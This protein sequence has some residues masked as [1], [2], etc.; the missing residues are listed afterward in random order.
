VVARDR[1]V[2]LAGG[3]PVT[4]HRVPGIAD[5]AV[6]PGT[7]EAA[8]LRRADPESVVTLGDRVIFRG[9]GDFGGL[10]WSPDGRML[11]V[12]WPTADQWVFVRADGRSRIAAVSNVREQFGGGRFPSVA[13]WCCAEQAG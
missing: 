7:G 5:V 6:R 13:G 3:R 10:E 2:T 9:T 11:L 12:T 4:E 8:V 1:L